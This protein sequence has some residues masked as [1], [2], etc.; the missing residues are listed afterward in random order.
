[1]SNSPPL[2]SSLFRPEDEALSLEKRSQVALHRVLTLLGAV[3]IPF[4]GLLHTISSPEATDPMW[5]RLGIGGGLLGFLA[6]SYGSRRVRRTYVTGTWTVIYAVMTWYVIVVALN[7]FASDYAV[8]LFLLYAIFPIVVGIGARTTTPVLWFLGIEFALTAGGIAIGGEAQTSPSI[9]LAGMAAIAVGEAILVRARLLTQKDLREREARLKGFTNNIPGVVYQLCI[10]SDGT[11]EYRFVSEHAERVLGLS[12]D[13]KNFQERATECVPAS[14]RDELRASIEEAVEKEQPW[15]F[16][17][18]FEKP[19]GERVWLLGAS[20]PEKREDELVFNGVILDVTERK[21]REREAEHRANAMEAAT[22]GMAVLDA[23]GRYTYVNQAH[24]TIY[25]YESPEVFIGKTWRICYDEDEGQRL[26]EEVMPVLFE[27]GEWRGE[28]VGCRADGSHFPQELTLTTLDNGGIICVVRDITERKQMEN[29]LREQKEQLRTINENV[30]EGIYRSSPEGGLVYANHAFADL[31]GY[32]SAVAVQEIHVQRLY[33]NPDQRG[34]LGRRL[35]EQGHVEAVEI[36][37]QRQDGTTF[38]G[39]LSA[40]T[41][42]DNDGEVTYYDGSITDITERKR[43]E[44]ILHRQREKIEALY[45]A[46][47]RLLTADNE[48]EVGAFVVDLVG[49]TLGYPGV[50]VWFAQE[51]RLVPTQVLPE[52]GEEGAALSSLNLDDASVLTDVFRR[53]E[54]VAVEDVREARAPGHCQGARTAAGVP[55]S[56]QGVIWVV[57][58]EPGE[59]DPFDLRLIE[60]LGAHATVV[61]NGLDQMAGLREAK[62]EAERMNQL[63]SA[64][65]ANMSHEIRTPL[66][67][68]IGF[69]ETIGE[70]IDEGGKGPVPRFAHLIEESGSRLLETLNG[71]LNLSK[72]ESGEIEISPEPVD[73]AEEVEEL[74][75]MFGPQAEEAGVDLHIEGTDAPT[76]GQVDR[77]GLQIAL[78][79][80][81]SNALKYTEADGQVWIRVRAEETSAVIEVE[82]TGIGM[83][84]EEVSELFEPF[85]QGSEGVGRE[86][87][88]SG[89][90]LAVTKRVVRRMNGT[91][92][93]RTERGEGTCF[94]VH[95]PRPEDACEGEQ[96]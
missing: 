62:E 20:T 49:E 11:S 93:V 64:F 78:R 65:L 43:R 52:P 15:H 35:E 6:A 46:T 4:F 28:N 87:E 10:R 50:S 47:N 37:L 26:E 89:L 1:M 32:E 82:D 53:S 68:I 72:L 23:D 90:G 81:V 21:R 59:F 27:E 30:S 9:L 57:D 36:E 56:G 14:H 74:A 80:L 95:L 86:Y 71:V 42:R 61:L 69:A 44:R 88:G 79:N 17:M 5:T 94:I 77:A 96:A 8:G 85:R 29:R 13:P 40:T 16:E 67:S 91:I 75:A 60:I 48:E 51:D 7:R 45:A 55:M 39:L 70:E 38:V 76:R 84:P 31:F 24:A 12:A 2:F 58:R 25:G 63:K 18:P 54:T 83:A 34:K 73:L 33:A 3:L 19:S 66:T 22:D 92:D 41:V